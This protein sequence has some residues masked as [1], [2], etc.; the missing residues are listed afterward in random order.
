MHLASAVGTPVIVP[1]GSTSPELTGP[2]FASNARIIKTALPCSPCFQRTCPIEYRCLQGITPE[3]MV[4]ETLDLVKA[5][6][7]AEIKPGG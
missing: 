5:F 6:E 7:L 2:I 1:F 4:Q 3:R